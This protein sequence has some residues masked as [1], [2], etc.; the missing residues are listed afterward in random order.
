MLDTATSLRYIPALKSDRVSALL[1]ACFHGHFKGDLK[2]VT[3]SDPTWRLLSALVFRPAE[4]GIMIFEDV[5]RDYRHFD[6]TKALNVEQAVFAVRNMAHFH[7]AWWKAFH[8]GDDFLGGL[9]REA[10]LKQYRMKFSKAMLQDIN[11]KTW[12]TI[13]LMVENRKERYGHLLP[14]YQA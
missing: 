13:E 1:P 6:H 9:D 7:G 3:G 10:F 12:K 11:K 8:E 2:P 4:K 14:R 5:S